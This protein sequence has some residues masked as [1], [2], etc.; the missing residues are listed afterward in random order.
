MFQC[1][2]AIGGKLEGISPTVL[3]PACCKFRKY[4]SP[5]ETITR[6]RGKARIRKI[7]E[8]ALVF[9]K[10]EFKKVGIYTRNNIAVIPSARVAKLL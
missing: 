7:S 2:R 9:I 8:P 1:G 10:A 6:M 3:M 4:I 5:I